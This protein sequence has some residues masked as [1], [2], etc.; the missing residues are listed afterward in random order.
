[1]PTPVPT[2]VATEVPQPTLVPPFGNADQVALLSGNDIYLMNP[3]G[4]GLTLVRTDNAAKS[5]LHWIPG[6]RL[7]Y[8]S[9]NCAYMLDGMSRQSVSPD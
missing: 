4:S 8:M 1:M 5:G 2:D 9:R 7:I 3:D 6:D